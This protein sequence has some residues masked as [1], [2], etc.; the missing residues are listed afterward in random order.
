MKKKLSLIL[1]VVLLL[2]T[3]VACDNND[4]NYSYPEYIFDES[5]T[6]LEEYTENIDNTESIDESINEIYSDSNEYTTENNE[7]ITS[8]TETTASEISTNVES[9][10][11][12]SVPAA[13]EKYSTEEITEIT[14]A[15]ETSTDITEEITTIVTE[16][17]PDS[18]ENKTESE[19]E[20]V[21]IHKDVDENNYCDICG[22]QIVVET[23]ESSSANEEQGSTEENID[24]RIIF[25]EFH[26]KNYTA[27]LQSHSN[28]GLMTEK[29]DT[30]SCGGYELKFLNYVN[31]YKNAR[32]AKGNSALKIGKGDAIGSFEL[33]VPNDIEIV[34]INVAKYKNLDTVI[35]VNNREHTLTKSSDNGEY[36]IIVIDVSTTKT[37]VF[38]TTDAG[39]RCMLRSIEFVK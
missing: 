8:D 34:V 23:E 2:S 1:S 21:S 31:V 19:T 13:T 24:G 38:S 26:D 5:E 18:T 14:S 27:G 22:T 20:S 39:M 11:T 35:K 33:H 36:D 3:V 32:D 4:Y 12:T 28:G 25:D 30:Y 17:V 16:F 15:S 37:I 9:A 7:D 6:F 10:E 29:T